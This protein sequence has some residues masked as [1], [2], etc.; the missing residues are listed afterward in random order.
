MRKAWPVGLAACVLAFAAPAH[1][2]TLGLAEVRSADGTLLAKAGAGV[3]A[4]PADGS[5]LRIGGARPRAGHVALDHAAQRRGDLLEQ[6]LIGAG[7]AAIG[8]A[9]QIRPLAILVREVAHNPL[10]FDVRQRY[11]LSSP[12]GEQGPPTEHSFVSP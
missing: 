2:G 3:Y 8:C 4:Y 11:S 6:P 10:R 7:V 12:P 5:I 9:H 1:A